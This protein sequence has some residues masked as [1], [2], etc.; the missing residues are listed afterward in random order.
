MLLESRIVNA[1]Q[2]IDNNI[3]YVLSGRNGVEPKQVWCLIDL[4]YLKSFGMADSNT[5]SE[6][7]QTTNYGTQRINQSKEIKLRLTYHGSA[8]SIAGERALYMETALTS[9]YGTLAFSDNGLSILSKSDLKTIDIGYE[10]S[11]FKRYILDIDI[12]TVYSEEYKVDVI[13]DVEVSG[14]LT[15]GNQDLDFNVNS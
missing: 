5:R 2:T 3:T 15:G 12:L 8:T 9:F 13:E 14:T 4:P 1:L 7:D 11:M 6:I 10:T